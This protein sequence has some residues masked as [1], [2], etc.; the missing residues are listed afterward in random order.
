MK[1]YSFFVKNDETVKVLAELYES[2]ILSAL[3]NGGMLI[4]DEFDAS[5]YPMV[6]IKRSLF[7]IIIFLGKMK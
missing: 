1:L 6:L 7:L 2:F 5:L 3:Q 4:L